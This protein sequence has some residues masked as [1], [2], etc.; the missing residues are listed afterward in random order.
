MLLSPEELV[1]LTGKT[2]PSSQAAVLAALGIPSKA[3]PDKSLVVLRVAVQMALGHHQDPS[4]H[5]RRPQLRIPAN[6]H[7]TAKA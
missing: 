5:P 4:A 2:R 3:R 7:A 1:E 6:R